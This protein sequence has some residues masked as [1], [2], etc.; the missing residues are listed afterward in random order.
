MSGTEATVANIESGAMEGIKEG[1]GMMN[2]LDAGID[3]STA[4]LG[5]IQG[6]V[7]T[8]VVEPGK[9]KMAEGEETYD[10]LKG[11]FGDQITNMGTAA[12]AKMAENAAKRAGK[13]AWEITTGTATEMKDDAVENAQIVAREGEQAVG[14]AE[15]AYQEEINKSSVTTGVTTGGRRRRRRRRTRRKKRRKSRKSRRKRR[16]SRKKKRRRSRK[17]RG[18]KSRK[19]SRRRRRR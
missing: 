17:R 13:S 6:D 7:M 5:D 19:K 4:V 8:K 3:K 12:Q 11:Q 14:E 9:A 1:Q 2:M 16:K 10:N 18:G 15:A